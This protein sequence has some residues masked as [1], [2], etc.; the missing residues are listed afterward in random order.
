M[1]GVSRRRCSKPARLSVGDEAVAGIGVAAAAGA[2]AA[3]AAVGAAGTTDGRDCAAAAPVCLA[4]RVPGVDVVFAGLERFGGFTDDGAPAP[5]AAAV[6]G[7]SAGAAIWSELS[8]AGS[9]SLR[10][11]AVGGATGC[12]AEA[13]G[14]AAGV[15]SRPPLGRGAVTEG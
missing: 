11:A 1:G 2:A 5:A 13:G 4:G 15:T 6:P 8:L 3:A 7:T 10:G 9:G 12:A 14:P